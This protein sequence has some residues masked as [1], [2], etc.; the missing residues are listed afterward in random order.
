M[1]IDSEI[2][3]IYIHKKR[4][5]GKPTFFSHCP[6]PRILLLTAKLLTSD[7]NQ[8]PNW[9]KLTCFVDADYTEQLLHHL[10]QELSIVIF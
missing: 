6:E 2:V 10:V 4:P 7:T 9:R 3:H 1:L 8:F 5:K